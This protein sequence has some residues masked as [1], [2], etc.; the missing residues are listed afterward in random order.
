MTSADDSGALT[1]VCD[2]AGR[3]FFAAGEA[4]ARIKRTLQQIGMGPGVVRRATIVAYEAE[5]NI[6]IHAR[7]GTLT[8]IIR[9]DRV[10]LVAADEGP[11]I[12]DVDLAMT[13]G[14]STAPDEIREL[15]FGA[16]MGLPNIQR[17]SD[18]LKIDT[19]VGHGTTVTAIIRAEK[20]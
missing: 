17:N 5:M 4:A 8:A 15:G 10:E 3:D 18:Q 9:P 6:V 14:F 11:G 1:L 20:E 19:V 16:G 12:P 2:V 7:H 13:E